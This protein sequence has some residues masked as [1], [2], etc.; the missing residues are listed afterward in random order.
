MKLGLKKK[1][2][3]SSAHKI[4]LDKGTGVYLWGSRE[5]DW[6]VLL[7]IFFLLLA[8]VFGGIFFTWY[9]PN[10]IKPEVDATPG[11]T[12]LNREVLSS[13]LKELSD[14]RFMFNELQRDPPNLQDPSQ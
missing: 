12:T 1:K 3:K 10:K 6:T 14:Q 4:K 8:G 7:I 2:K 5:R 13:V 9:G 11:V